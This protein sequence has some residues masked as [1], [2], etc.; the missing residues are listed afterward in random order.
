VG[1]AHR[2]IVHIFIL[3]VGHTNPTSDIVK[4]EMLGEIGFELIREAQ[5]LS[6][7]ICLP[8]LLLLHNAGCVVAKL[9]L[10]SLKTRTT[11]IYYIHNEILPNT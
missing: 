5:S 11:S 9:A 8:Y 1:I 4:R 3:L 10:L 7:S 2:F 6:L